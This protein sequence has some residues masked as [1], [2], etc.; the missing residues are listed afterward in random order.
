MTMLIQIIEDDPHYAKLLI[1]ILD[2]NPLLSFSGLSTTKAEALDALM[3]SPIADVFLLDVGLPD[4]SGLDLIQ[5]ILK[6]KPSAV[7]ILLSTL[8]ARNSILSA[9][10]LG[11]VGYVMKST[12]SGGILQH[13]FDALN[14]GAT[15]SPSL[16]KIAIDAVKEPV[17]EEVD[18]VVHATHT[19][20]PREIEILNLLKDAHPSKRIASML[21]VSKFTVSQHLRN[22]YRKLEAKN[23]V[24]AISIA[25]IKKIIV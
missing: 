25:R 17:I 3:K 13:I 2:G 20:T 18:S 9:I 10:N 11:A 7:I 8:G 16:I 4:G 19:L 22:V 1:G 15:L 24:D 14:Y 6:A 21:N 23:R 12:S 5:P